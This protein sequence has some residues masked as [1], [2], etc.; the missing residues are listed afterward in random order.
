MCFFALCLSNSLVLDHSF[1]DVIVIIIIVT[2]TI[3][4]IFIVVREC[5]ICVHQNPINTKSF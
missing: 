3:V 4:V 1:S 5:C 2:T